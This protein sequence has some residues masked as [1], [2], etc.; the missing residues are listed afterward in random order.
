LAASLVESYGLTW[1]VARKGSEPWK[2]S[3]AIDLVRAG[4]RGK[5]F[6]HAEM[7]GGPLWLQPQVIGRAKDD[8]RVADADD[9]RLW[10]LTSLAGGARGILYLRWRSLLDGPLFGAFGLYDTDGLPNPRT[11]AASKIAKWANAD[12]QKDLFRSTPVQGD[13]GIVVVPETQVFNRLLAQA[14][15]GEFYTKCM[16]GVYQ[17]FYDNHIQ[18]DWVRLEHI[19]EYNV[20]YLPYPIKLSEENTKRL[21]RWVQNGGT[22]ISEGCPA[23]FGDAGKVGVTQ[24]N[25]GLDQVFGTQQDEVEFMP[26]LSGQIS[27]DFEGNP[28]K[29][30]LFLQSYRPTTG[31]TKGAYSDGRIA[32]VENRFGKGKTLL[33]G[34]FPSEGYHRTQDAGTR[35]FYQDIFSWTGRKPQ[36]TV[37]NP[38]VRVRLQDGDGGKFAWIL[39]PHHSVQETRVQISEEYGAVSADKVLWGEFN[40]T[41]ENNEFVIQVPA[42]DAVV[43][44]FKS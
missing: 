44:K 4:S 10:N 38:N 12:A 43:L 27:L 39:N 9:V 32:V 41:I 21:I 17:A 42:Q 20:L 25:Y 14:G 34:T 29:G 26:D 5:P 13:I 18:A 6:W 35:T 24:P 33:I 2:Q 22:L 7:Q 40:G 36:V 11:E 15:E 23:Y 3:H 8:G 1:V 37:S 16:W 28:L 31:T 19:D 30:G